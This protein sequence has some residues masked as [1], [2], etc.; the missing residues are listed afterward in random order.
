M[1]LLA[2]VFISV[3]LWV[4]V[5]VYFLIAFLLI[6]M[7]E[8]AVALSDPFGNEAVHFD[9]DHFMARIMLNVKSIVSPEATYSRQTV[10]IP[11]E[12]VTALTQVSS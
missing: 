12:D 3:K 11:K 7:K 6:G 5:P 4:S 10:D 2:Y 8:T 1:L 9:C